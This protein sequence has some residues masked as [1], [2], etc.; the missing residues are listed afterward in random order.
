M[1]HNSAPCRTV[2]AL[3]LNSC[4]TPLASHILGGGDFTGDFCFRKTEW[5]S[6]SYYYFLFVCFV[7]FILLGTAG[8]FQRTGVDFEVTWQRGFLPMFTHYTFKYDTLTPI[9]R[10]ASVLLSDLPAAHGKFIP[11]EKVAFFANAGGV[12]L[13]R[14]FFFKLLLFKY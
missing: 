13:H 14:Q 11:R 1:W 3:S 10:T 4:E 5:M 9:H 12:M 2:G 8:S 7:L 6:A